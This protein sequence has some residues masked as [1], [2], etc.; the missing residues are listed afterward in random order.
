MAS[1]I[2]HY[3]HARLLGTEYH[4]EHYI[5]SLIEHYEHARSLGTLLNFPHYLAD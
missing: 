5:A 4:L 2:E 1:L 3:E